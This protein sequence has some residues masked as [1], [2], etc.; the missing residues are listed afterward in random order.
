MANRDDYTTSTADRV[1]CPACDR[2]FLPRKDG[3]VRSHN[4]RDGSW[5]PMNCAGTGKTP[6]E[7]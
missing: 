4:A 1:Q 5:P 7:Q 6:K 2:W 3:K